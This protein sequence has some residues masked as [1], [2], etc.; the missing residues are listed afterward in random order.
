MYNIFMKNKT[1]VIVV[2]GGL[3]GI[4]AAITVAKAG[5]EVVLIEG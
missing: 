1:Q 2:G 4:S 3:A 5:K